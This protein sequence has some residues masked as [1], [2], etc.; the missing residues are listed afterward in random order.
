MI[1]PI[2]EKLAEA[3]GDH[4]EFYKVDVDAVP[5]V[6][7]EVGIKAVSSDSD[8]LR[9]APLLLWRCSG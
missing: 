1:S 7:Q 6:A 3:A 2:F 5:D 9:P 4:V 8:V